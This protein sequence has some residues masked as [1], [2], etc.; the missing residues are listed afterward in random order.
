MAPA[1]HPAGLVGGDRGGPADRVDQRVVGRLAAPPGPCDR[2]GD[3][4]DA[5]LHAELTEQ[6]SD[7]PGRAPSYLTISTIKHHQRDRPRPQRRAA[8]PSASEVYS[9][10]RGCTLDLQ[11]R[12]R[13]TVTS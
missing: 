3:P 9:G 10:W 13:P 1:T 4:A 11:P 6:R 5:D 12:H 8:A 7:P 2:L